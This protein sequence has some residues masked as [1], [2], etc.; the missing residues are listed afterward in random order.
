MSRATPAKGGQM[1]NRDLILL[2]TVKTHRARL[3]S[4]FVYGELPERRLANDNV[5]R[6]IGGI[7][8]TAVLCAGCVGFSFVMGIR[9]DQAAAARE[10]AAL[11]PATGEIVAA[12]TFDRR[13]SEGWG[14]AERGGKWRVTDPARDYS[15]AGGAGVMQLPEDKRR[16][17]YL[18][19]Q[20]LDRSDVT[21]TVQR[22]DGARNGSVNVA[23]TGRRVSS[24]Q[25]Y[26][27]NLRL[28][29]DGSVALSL[30][31][32]AEPGSSGQREE[33]LSPTVILFGADDDPESDP[34]PVAVRI[35]VIGTSP[36]TVRAKAWF[37][38]GAEPTGWTVS[39]TDSTA[40]LQRPGSIGVSAIRTSG[41]KADADL[42]VTDVVAR[43]AP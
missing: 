13:T 12:D 11:G 2:E 8:L 5:R 6:L 10:K 25:D 43:V 20:L 30:S 14:G 34:Q 16:S 32:R 33:Q 24:T 39:A 3:T 40:G 22:G 23:V 27:A 9:G 35:Q 17:A 26:R 41:S 31:R 36:T 18:P 37:A 1:P 38:N 21:A 19:A 42:S 7:V 28:T 4:A 15:V 29:D